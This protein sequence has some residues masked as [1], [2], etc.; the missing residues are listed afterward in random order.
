[1]AAP[2]L[3]FEVPQIKKEQLETLARALCVDVIGD[4]ESLRKACFERSFQV[5]Q[6]GEWALVDPIVKELSLLVDDLGR[7]LLMRAAMEQKGAVVRGLTERAIG[8][9]TI[10]RCGK[11]VLHYLMCGAAGVSSHS[12]AA[13]IT[14][15]LRA[16]HSQQ[17]LT[18][19]KQELEQLDF[20]YQIAQSLLKDIATGRVQSAQGIDMLQT[21]LKQH[22]KNF[23]YFHPGLLRYLQLL[24][25]LQRSTGSQEADATRVEYE[26]WF[27]TL[28]GFAPASL[29]EFSEKNL[30]ELAKQGLDGEVDRFL[31][32]CATRFV[33]FPEEI[34]GIVNLICSLT[35]IYYHSGR[36]ER[37]ICTISKIFL[38]SEDL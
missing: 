14:E 3:H 25:K 11:T 31:E 20:R 10:D 9:T 8:I 15:K 6:R 27:S 22:Q 4:S 29:E 7:T 30:L 26:K 35:N 21:L 38:D 17:A 24:E 28:L 1:M 37:A 32:S 23:G 2:G 12:Y 36:H 16:Q 5:C 19:L 33:I 18:S 34:T 13:L